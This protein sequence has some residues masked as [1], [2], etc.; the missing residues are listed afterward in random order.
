MM[1]PGTWRFS[2]NSARRSATLTRTSSKAIS[3]AEGGPAEAGE[4]NVRAMVISPSHCRPAGPSAVI[5][6]YARR[7]RPPIG[8]WLDA[9]GAGYAGVY[10]AGNLA[11]R[12]SPVDTEI[13]VVNAV[14]DF[15]ERLRLHQLAAGQE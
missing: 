12:L 2:S 6:R 9:L 15:V 8:N 5:S 13:I 3:F 7:D 10:V 11:R 1:S 14:P 4:S